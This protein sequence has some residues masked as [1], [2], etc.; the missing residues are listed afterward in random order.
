M[1]LLNLLKGKTV[2]VR[3]KL[4]VKGVLVDFDDNFI[5]IQTKDCKL[6]FIPIRDVV[7]IQTEGH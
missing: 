4:T 6:Y 5:E 3:A 2:T 1:S 7:S